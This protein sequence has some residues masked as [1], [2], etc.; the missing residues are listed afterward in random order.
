MLGQTLLPVAIQERGQ[1]G[2]PSMFNALMAIIG[3]AYDIP[4][5]A[6]LQL[7]PLMPAPPTMPGEEAPPEEEPV[8]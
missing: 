5:L 3:E 8:A 7:Q 4:K 2:D 6:Q 1:T